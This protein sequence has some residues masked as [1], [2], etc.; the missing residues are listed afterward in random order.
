MESQES[1]EQRKSIYIQQK[2]VL[3][4]KLK[5]LVD[6]QNKVLAE[7]A[8]LDKPTRNKRGY[9]DLRRSEQE[10]VRRILIEGEEGECDFVLDKSEATI[11]D[12]YTN[13]K[14]V[15][16]P[17]VKWTKSIGYQLEDGTEIIQEHQEYLIKKII[18]P[19]FDT[20]PKNHQFDSDEESW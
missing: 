6:E 19:N 13:G 8:A 18:Q 14:I 20:G 11:K 1:F 4:N 12:G 10:R 15:L 2:T 9:D 16:K 5:Y 17:G 3:V 7:L